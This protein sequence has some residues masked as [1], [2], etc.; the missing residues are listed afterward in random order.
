MLS[1][2]NFR[3]S[4][5][6]F[7]ERIIKESMRPCPS[8]LSPLVSLPFPTS[9]SP[10]FLYLNRVAAFKGTFCSWGS[11][12][13]YLGKWM[14]LSLPFFF[15]LFKKSLYSFINERQREREVETQAEGEAGSLQGAQCGTRSQDSG[16]MTWATPLAC[17]IFAHGIIQKGKILGQNTPWCLAQ[18][19]VCR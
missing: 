14:F 7:L 11:L 17:F 4:I 8:P 12:M 15:L 6:R 19:C 10:A 3:L 13:F 16:I 5:K 18:K 9:Y 2:W 1:T